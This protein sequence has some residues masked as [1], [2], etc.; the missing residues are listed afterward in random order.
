MAFPPVVALSVRLTPEWIIQRISSQVFARV[1]ERHPMI[2]DRLGEFGSR[3]FGFNPTDINLSF[4]VRPSRRAI[5]VHA[6]P[7]TPAADAS[8]AGPLHLLLSL[9]EG[10]CDADAL[11]FSRD[12]TV[13]GDMEAM[14]ALRNALDDSDLDLPTDISS[15]AG[16]L[17][18]VVKR[19]A[20]YARERV[21]TEETAGWN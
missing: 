21:L 14:L 16:P 12:L 3:T 13:T 8:L 20:E 17:G 10:R 6:G 2:L 1:L 19:I 9:A 4:T 11:F 5:E 7:G 18:P 15:F